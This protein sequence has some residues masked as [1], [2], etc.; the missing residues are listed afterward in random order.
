MTLQASF[1]YGSGGTSCDA[2]VQTSID[3]ATWTDIANFHFTTS[4]AR[5][6]FNLSALT[7]HTSQV[8]PT[9]HT[10]GANSCVDGI[11]GHLFRIKYSSSGVY[12][13]NASLTVDAVSS[14]RMEPW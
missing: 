12:A 9:D 8:T 10:L 1:V 7:P 5:G 11:L 3:G 6:I 14:S 13:G 2:R 4:N